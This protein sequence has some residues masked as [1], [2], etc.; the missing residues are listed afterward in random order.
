MKTIL[1]RFLALTLLFTAFVA[2]SDDDDNP[3]PIVINDIMVVYNTDTGEFSAVDLTDG[4]LLLLGTATYNGSDLL[5][6]RDVVFNSADNMMYASSRATD[7]YHEGA[8][9]RIDPM[10]MQATMINDNANDDWYA[11]ANLEMDEGR[12]LGTVYW[13]EYDYDYWSSLVRLNLDGS[14]DEVIYLTYE[15]DDY[16]FSGGMALEFGD[17]PDEFLV[18][19]GN[20]I[21]ILNINGTVSDEFILNS[22]GFPNDDVGRGGGSSVGYVRSLERDAN[23]NLYGL[24]AD[25]HLGSINLNNETFTYITQF[26]AGGDI[27]ALIKLP[28][29]IFQ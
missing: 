28:E 23:G 16:G 11:V 5:G 8:L 14:I 1:F 26:D 19:D 22:A 17:N 3:P 13:D 4:S 12:L 7:Q 2:C 29:N 6:L 27:V 9:F 25:G 21:A 24:D 20:R 18:T 10:N 15:D